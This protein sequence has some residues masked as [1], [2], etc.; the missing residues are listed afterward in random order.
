MAKFNIQLCRSM[1]QY[2]TVFIEAETEEAAL[3]MVEED[4]DTAWL[5]ATIDDEIYPEDTTVQGIDIC[6]REL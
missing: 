2:A 3:E 1:Y 4:P 5:N 6:R